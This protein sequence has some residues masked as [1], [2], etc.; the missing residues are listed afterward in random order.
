MGIPFDEMTVDGV[1]SKLYRITSS[2]EAVWN[3]FATHYKRG[4]FYDQI[5]QEFGITPETHDKLVNSFDARIE[6][7]RIEANKRVDEVTNKCE[8]EI[9]RLATIVREKEAEAIQA[10][11]EMRKELER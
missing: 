5:E 11:Y 8:R 6:E 10:Q 7:Y 2:A 9:E 4:F 3:A 1:I